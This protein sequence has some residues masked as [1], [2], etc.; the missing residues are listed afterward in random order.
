MIIEISVAVIAAAFVILVAYIILL[1]KALR[2][3]LAQVDY[4]VVE[5]R[6]KMETLNGIF[7]SLSNI[8]E[9]VEYKSD[10]FKKKILSSEEKKATM[11]EN[12][13]KICETVG[14]IL[15]LIN[16]SIRFWEKLKG[17]QP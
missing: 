11:I 8:G 10:L 15:K 3:T 2:K 6:Q 12:E 7:K 9:V 16:I 17:V 5:V 4:T 1:I 14:D 13:A